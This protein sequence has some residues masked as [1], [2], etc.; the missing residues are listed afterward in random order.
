[1]P[2]TSGQNPMAAVPRK[3]VFARASAAGRGGTMREIRSCALI[4]QYQKFYL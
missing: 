2:V 3:R 1:M 4:P